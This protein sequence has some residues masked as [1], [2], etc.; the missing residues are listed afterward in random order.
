MEVIVKLTNCRVSKVID[1]SLGAMLV[2]R[3]NFCFKVMTSRYGD[4]YRIVELLCAP[5]NST[6][7]LIV[8]ENKPTL[9]TGLLPLNQSYP[10]WQARG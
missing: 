5:E 1:G 9:L 3:Y 6:Y 10:F 7:I 8:Q 4:D 2:E